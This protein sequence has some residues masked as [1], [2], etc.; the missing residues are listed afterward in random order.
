M[1]EVSARYFQISQRK[2]ENFG[3][4]VAITLYNGAYTSM[5]NSRHISLP[6]GC[7]KKGHAT[8]GSYCVLEISFMDKIF[9]Y[10][11]EI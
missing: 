9:A 7:I 8:L 10:S 2:Y 6:A 3:D 5:P 1:W 4:V 11:N